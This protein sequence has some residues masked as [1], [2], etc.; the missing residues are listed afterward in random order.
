MKFNKKFP[1]V[2]LGLLLFLA[3]VAIPT[4]IATEKPS[5][6][7]LP[8]IRT[9]PPPRDETVWMTGSYNSPTQ[10]LPWSTSLPPGADAGMYEALFGYNSVTE[11]LVPCI[12]TSYEWDATGE[13]VTIHLN[14]HARWSDGQVLDADDVVYSYEVAE[15]QP[16]YTTDFQA[17]FADFV[18]I[19]ATTVRFVMNPGFYF[20]RQVELWLMYNIPIV[21]EHVWTLIETAKSGDL[22]TYQYD[23]FENSG[24][25]AALPA[26]RVIS[27]PYAPV[28]RDALESTCAYQYRE[29]WWGAGRL[30]QDLPNAGATPPKYIGTIRFESNTEQDLAF[31]QGNIDL[32]AGYYHHIWEIWENAYPGSPGTYIYCWYGRDP[33]YQLAASAL[34]NLAP[35]HLLPN[36]PLGIKEF[37]QALAYGINYDPIPAAAASGYWTQ[38]KPGYIDNNSA[39]HKPYYDAAITAQYQKYENVAKA[40]S[41]LE[42]IPLMVHNP[43]GTWTYDGTPV[44]PYE[45]ICPYGWTD[46]IAFTD[47]V[48]TDISTNLN[49]SISTLLVDY[50]PTYKNMIDSSSYDFAMFVGG[51]RLAD[52]PQ[53]FLDC[54][55]GEHL[56]NKNVSCWENATFETLWQTL[57]TANPTDYANNLDAMQLILAQEVPEIPGFVNGYWYAFSNYLWEGW[58]SA[59]NNFQQLVTSWTDDHFV[60]KTRLMLN[61]KS[62][63]AAPVGAAIPWFG[64]ELFILIGVVS[65]TI[66]MGF[67]IKT[68]RE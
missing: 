33:P 2:I 40:V 43:D 16:R 65:A 39:L 67:K 19:D 4:V 24:P 49:I 45:A 59:D 62:T 53:R 10:F 26:W 29:D 52:P 11:E 68:K 57:E 66:A 56:W 47:M 22:S 44:G 25:N 51:N 14:S 35:N 7:G 38:A 55:R 8:A 17:R 18:K 42:S 3:M 5:P 48:T 23:W 46:A 36:S 1:F 28:Y 64:L 21:P 13:N 58:A 31:I 63:G 61:L 6:S 34:M 27:G 50:E 54:M 37:R 9:T 20:S 15:R 12:G 41:L 30:Y 60:I 32:Y